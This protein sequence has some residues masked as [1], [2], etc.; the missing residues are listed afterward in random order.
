VKVKKYWNPPLAIELIGP[1]TSVCMSS[2][3]SD[4]LSGKPVNGVLVILPSKQASHVSYDS[5]SNEVRSPSEWS[6][7]RFSLI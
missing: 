1:Y 4:A 5:K 2:S 3:K 7:M 6:F